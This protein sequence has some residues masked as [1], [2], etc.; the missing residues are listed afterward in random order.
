MKTTKKYGLE[1]AG[2]RRVRR[3]GWL[4]LLT[5]LTVLTVITAIVGWLMWLVHRASTA[6]DVMPVMSGMRPAL[7]AAGFGLPEWV[8]YGLVGTL[9]MSVLAL[10]A[11]NAIMGP[12]PAI[13]DGDGWADAPGIDVEESTEPWMAELQAMMARRHVLVSVRQ[14]RQIRAL[15]VPRHR[16]DLVM[17]DAF[18]RRELGLRLFVTSLKEVQAICGKADVGGKEGAAA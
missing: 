15:C 8:A 2:P 11:W 12:R 7:R 14:C 10:S 4:T 9:T 13:E 3:G 18:L 6:G 17:L 16:M 5:A 1:F